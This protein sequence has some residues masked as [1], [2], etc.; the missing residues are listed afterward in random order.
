MNAILTETSEAKRDKQIVAQ[1][2]SSVALVLWKFTE[3]AVQNEYPGWTPG[4]TPFALSVPKLI[5]LSFSH[6]TLIFIALSR[7]PMAPPPE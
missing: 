5:T 6:S 1:A 3:R 7:L 2:P 4:L